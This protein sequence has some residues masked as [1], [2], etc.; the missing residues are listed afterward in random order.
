M[1]F[2]TTSVLDDFNRADGDLGS[3]WTEGTFGGG[4]EY[5]ILSNTVVG[6]T[7]QQV[8]SAYWNPSTFG[9]DTEAFVTFAVLPFEA[10]DRNSLVLRLDPS[11]DT[12]WDGYILDLRPQNTQADYQFFIQEVTNSTKTQLG[13]AVNVTISAGHKMGFEAIGSTLKGYQHNGTSWSEIRSR[14]DTTHTAAGNIGITGEFDNNNDRPKYDDFGGGTVAA[15]AVII[16]LIM[17][18]YIPT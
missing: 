4:D 8:D 2:P 5:R 6:Q 15:G 11:G 1:A 14:T 3:N 9:A 12:T 7:D 13:A 10:G 17:A 18:P 16:N